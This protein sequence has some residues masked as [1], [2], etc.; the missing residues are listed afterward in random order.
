MSKKVKLTNEAVLMSLFAAFISAGCFIQ[1]PF[2]GGVPIV[3]QDMFAVFAGLML[4]GLYGV[5][6]VMIFLCL[7]ILGL[8]VFSGKAGL[9]VILQGVTGGFLV[10]YLFAAFV[11]GVLS[12]FFLKKTFGDIKTYIILIISSVIAMCIIFTCGVVGFMRVT[13]CDLTKAFAL[14]VVPFMPGTVL[15]INL[16]V[17]LGKKF[18]PIINNYISR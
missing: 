7:G 14:V 2:F 9:H 17:L 1:I 11:A 6:A 8:P 15:K 4:G 16:L 12:H 3:F 5:G 18:C 13:G 10:G